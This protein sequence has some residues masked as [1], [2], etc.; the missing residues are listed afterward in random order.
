MGELRRGDDERLGGGGSE[1]GRAGRGQADMAIKSF[2]WIAR[3]SRRGDHIG[4]GG[5]LATTNADDGYRARYQEPSVFRMEELWSRMRSMAR[6]MPESPFIVTLWLHFSRRVVEP[7]ECAKTPGGRTS[8]HREVLG[9]GV[10]F[11]VLWVNYAEE[12]M[13]DWAVG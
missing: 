10:I 13:S 7:L 1:F 12:L 6:L 8:L 9:A 11:T 2:A 5:L 4:V 3:R